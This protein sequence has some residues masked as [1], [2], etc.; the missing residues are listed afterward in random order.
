MRL[1]FSLNIDGPVIRIR[2]KLWLE[3]DGELL[4]GEGRARLLRLIQEKRSINSAAKAM[5]ITFRRAWSMVKD[6]EDTI[7]VTLVSKKRGGLGGG[8]TTL[9]PIAVELLEHYEK[10]LAEFNEFANG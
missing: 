4:I 6:M 5:G 2:T 8:T 3:L 10:I 9:T 1:D 7:K